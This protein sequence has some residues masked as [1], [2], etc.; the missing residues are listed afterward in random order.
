[1]FI[2]TL[3]IKNN[4]L[5]LFCPTSSNYKD[6]YIVIYKLNSSYF[7][8]RIFILK[9]K[10]FRFASKNPLNYDKSQ[11]FFQNIIIDMSWNYPNPGVFWE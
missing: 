6:D 11:L 10:Y 2:N 3:L 8:F 4:S 9:N 1:M 7:V 5:T